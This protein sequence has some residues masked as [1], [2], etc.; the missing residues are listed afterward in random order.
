MKKV[1]QLSGETGVKDDEIASDKEEPKEEE[2]DK[3]PSCTNTPE[4]KSWEDMLTCT[5]PGSLKSLHMIAGFVRSTIPE[6]VG[7][8]MSAASTQISMI[9]TKISAAM[10]EDY[11]SVPNQK[12]PVSLIVWNLFDRK[13]YLPLSLF[14]SKAMRRLHQ[15]PS[16]CS[17]KNISIPNEGNKIPVLNITPFGKEKDMLVPDWHEAK[18]NH[19][20]FLLK[21]FDDEV[22][23]RWIRHHKFLASIDNF[24]KLFVM[25]VQFDISEC[26]NYTFQPMKF[27]K[28]VYYQKWNA[29]KLEILQENLELG[30]KNFNSSCNSSSSPTCAQHS[31]VTHAKPYKRRPFPEG[32]GLSTRSNTCL[33]CARP[34]HRANNCTKTMLEKGGNI[35]CA[36]QEGKLARSF[37]KRPSVLDGTS[38]GN[39]LE[40][41]VT[42]SSTLAHSVGNLTTMPSLTPVIDT[43]ALSRII[44]PMSADTFDSILATTNSTYKYPKLAS[45]IRNSFPIRDPDALEKTTTVS[46]GITFITLMTWQ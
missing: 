32:R 33:I 39:V 42:P 29:T 36:W 45:K 19:K 8:L 23:G 10:E 6:N 2:S 25:I 43:T 20:I 41:T 40:D 46:W 35:A 34:R 11:S 4:P 14:T 3:E 21:A 16:S 28:I 1:H 9:H 38:L 7:K 18:A 5:S 22:A 17:M 27:N 13:Q 37:L 44:M 30:I 26:T 12:Y 24:K 15:D 31:S